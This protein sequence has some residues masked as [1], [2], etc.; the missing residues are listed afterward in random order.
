MQCAAVM[1]TWVPCT[2]VRDAPQWWRPWYFMLSWYGT[3]PGVVIVPSMMR[4]RGG[5]GV[6]AVENLDF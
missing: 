1:A 6:D 4:G 3:C 5:G 2:S